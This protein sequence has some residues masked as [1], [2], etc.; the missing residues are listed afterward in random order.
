MKRTICVLSLVL[1]TVF[2]AGN[3]LAA[4]GKCKVVKVEGTRMEI[5]CGEKTK[6]F[7]KGTKIKIKTEK[8]KAIEGC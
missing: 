5:D 7:Q 2:A 4:S 6:G 8:K 3:I 1:A